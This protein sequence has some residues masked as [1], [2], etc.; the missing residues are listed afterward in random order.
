MTFLTIRWRATRPGDILDR[1][2]RVDLS[3]AGLQGTRFRGMEAVRPFASHVRRRWL[4]LLL[5]ALALRSLADGISA[6]R[7]FQD[8]GAAQFTEFRLIAPLGPR[9]EALP[10][11][12]SSE[13]AAMVSVRLLRRGCEVLTHTFDGRAP[14]ALVLPEPLLLDGVEIWVRA[15]RRPQ[16]TPLRLPFFTPMAGDF[17]P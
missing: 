8:Y 4:Q 16:C 2:M 13:A 17:N 5:A 11:S 9:V 3:G 7:G 10:P 14:E 1:R 6:A 15:A 12:L